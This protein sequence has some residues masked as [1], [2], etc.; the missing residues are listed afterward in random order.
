MQAT[1]FRQLISVLLVWDAEVF[2]VS[3]PRKKQINSIDIFG[4]KLWIAQQFLVSGLFF[5]CLPPFTLWMDFPEA[6]KQVCAFV[7]RVFHSLCV[8]WR[9]SEMKSRK[10]CLFVC[11]ER[12]AVDNSNRKKM[13][14][15]IWFWRLS[16]TRKMSFR[17]RFWECVVT[18]STDVSFGSFSL[19][20]V[21]DNFHSE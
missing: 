16:T 7:P 9:T 20:S 2:N 15:L 10:S 11:F 21:C 13:W 19:C 14:S 6:A 5:R 17:C 18:P 1:F 3:A 4:D 8:F 12:L